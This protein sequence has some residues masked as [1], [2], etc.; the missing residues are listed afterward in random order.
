MI[1]QLYL[2]QPMIGI[3]TYISNMHYIDDKLQFIVIPIGAQSQQV[4][5]DPVYIL[6]HM[7]SF[8][9]QMSNGK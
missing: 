9:D 8:W 7:S 4:N 5:V 2:Q 3:F 1:I 6:F